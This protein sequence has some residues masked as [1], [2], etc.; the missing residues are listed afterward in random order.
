[1]INPMKSYAILIHPGHNRVYYDNAMNLM[2]EEIKAVMLNTD[3]PID[4]VEPTM[5]AKIP[6]VTFQVE[7]DLSHEAT[8][9]LGRLSAFFA[10][11]AVEA[12]DMLRPILCDAK[13]KFPESI[14]TILKY[15]GKTN[16]QFTHLMINLATAACKTGTERKRLL[17]PLAG[18]GT[19][20]F[21][22]TRF[23]Y[24]T[25]GVET[26][27]KWIKEGENYMVRYLKTGRYKHKVQT[28]S[29]SEG[30]RKIA[31]MA[32]ITFAND[33]EAYQAGNTQLMSMIHAD[34][35]MVQKIVRKR[36]CDMIVADL[37]YGIQHA[38]KGQGGMK[39]K[40]ATALVKEALPSWL[41]A[42]RKGGSMVLSFNTHTTKRVELA[43][44]CRSHGMEVLEDAP[45]VGYEHA[46]DQAIKRDIL[47]CSL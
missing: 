22:A 7:G 38:S 2:L 31:K 26:N 25:V 14:N 18:K 4:G 17:D 21:E 43:A 13:Y 23:G 3:C 6:Y 47:V 45:F 1:M 40:S 29:K 28:E 9:M 5:I 20:L 37:P 27:E 30:K 36:S 19:T 24:D 8:M 33:K 42:L 15:I 39:S 41:S 16:E 32:H 12:G 44:V 35:R 11:Y 10:L 34:T 46:V